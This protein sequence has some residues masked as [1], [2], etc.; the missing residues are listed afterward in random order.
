VGHETDVTLADLAADVRAPTPTAAAE[1]ASPTQEEGL[2]LL[3]AAARVMQRRVYQVIDTEAQRLDRATLRLRR[4]ADLVRRQA[5][6]VALLRQRL[7]ARAARHVPQQRQACSEAQRRLSRSATVALASHRQR[8]A[9]LQARLAT[10][11]PRQVLAR[12]YAW[13]SDEQGHALTSVNDL[14]T[15]K[16]VTAELADGQVR[17][18]VLSVQRRIAE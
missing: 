1:M 7:Q 16:T 10:L 17:A 4:P 9:A 2:A 13:L 11:D 5:E 15:G 12:G 8:L 18:T 14:A 6:R 3:A